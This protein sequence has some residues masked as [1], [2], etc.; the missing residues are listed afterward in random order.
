MLPYQ[1]ASQRCQSVKAACVQEVSGFG[2]TSG[3]HSRVPITAEPRMGIA[4]KAMRHARKTIRI[5]RNGVLTADGWRLTPV[6]SRLSI[7]CCS[8]GANCGLRSACPSRDAD[9]V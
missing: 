4:I 2:K 1:I 5:L 3:Q 9:K 7:G 6:D 8:A